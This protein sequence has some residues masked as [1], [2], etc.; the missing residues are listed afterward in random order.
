[1]RNSN[2]AVQWLPLIWIALTLLVGARLFARAAWE[3]RM[4]I[5]AVFLGGTL[6]TFIGDLLAQKLSTDLAVADRA[7]TLGVLCGLTLSIGAPIVAHF[8]APQ[9]QSEVLLV[10]S[11]GL[12]GLATTLTAMHYFRGQRTRARMSAAT[13]QESRSDK[14]ARNMVIALS[15]M[16]WATF[17]AVLLPYDWAPRLQRL[18]AVAVCCFALALL[19]GLAA[20]RALVRRYKPHS[21]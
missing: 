18:L 3:G 10:S 14:W 13:Q 17:G 16:A 9:S 4:S 1:M 8:A 6:I 21:D 2:K 11:C 15:I 5:A 12:A 20:A 19:L 7:R